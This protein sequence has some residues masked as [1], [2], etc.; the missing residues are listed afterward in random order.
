MDREANGHIV[1][2]F[3]Q[4]RPNVTFIRAGQAVVLRPLDES[5][6]APDR[7]PEPFRLVHLI[8]GG[9]ADPPR[10]GISADWEVIA[11]SDSARFETSRREL[12]QLR[13]EHIPGLVADLLLHSAD[14]PHRYVVLGLYATAGDLDLARGHPAVQAWAAEHPAG[15]LGARDLF[16]VSKFSVEVWENGW[17]TD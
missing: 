9:F 15:D 1:R 12:F 2:G 14:R 3:V 7:I 16:G 8:R 6:P 4:G 17:L 11:G 5:V 13:I 10:F